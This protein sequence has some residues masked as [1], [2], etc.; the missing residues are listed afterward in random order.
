[1]FRVRTQQANHRPVSAGVR[2]L[3]APASPADVPHAAPTTTLPSCYDKKSR[4][5][6][7][8]RYTVCY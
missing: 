7:V 5:W 8:S 6:Y 2:P 4:K 3:G 1:M